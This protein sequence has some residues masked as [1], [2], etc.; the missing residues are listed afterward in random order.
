MDMKLIITLLS[1]SLLSGLYAVDN[2]DQLRLIEEAMIESATT[3]AQKTV[4]SRYMAKIANDKL[5]MAQKLREGAKLARGGKML[6]Q[7]SGQ[8]D[9]L[10]RAQILEKEAGA[11]QTLAEGEMVGDVVAINN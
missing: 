11:Y 6:Y 4:V 8:N 5:Q 3:P 7:T 10:K 2:N 9:L 1:F